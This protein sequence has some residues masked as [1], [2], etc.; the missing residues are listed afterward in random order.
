[1]VTSWNHRNQSSSN[2]LCVHTKVTLLDNAD[3]FSDCNERSL[4]G[5]G[6]PAEYVKLF[7]KLA[8]R[9]GWLTEQ[10][11]KLQLDRSTPETTTAFG[12]VPSKL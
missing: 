11:Q 2:R 5:S 7:C 10:Q 6:E 3:V 4:L 8:I 12:C 9:G 1:M